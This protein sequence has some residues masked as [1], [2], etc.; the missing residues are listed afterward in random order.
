ML[1]VPDFL[2][3]GMENWGLIIYKESMMLTDESSSSFGEKRLVTTIVCHEIAHQWFG[4]LVTLQWWD[5]LWLNEGFATYMEIVGLNFVNPKWNMDIEFTRS[6]DN[7]MRS[8]DTI[9]SHPI[10]VP[11]AHPGE[12]MKIFDIIS[13]LKCSPCDIVELEFI[14]YQLNQTL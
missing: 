4:N 9:S 12:I 5:D 2:I 1:A 13:Y 7:A 6:V 3:G 11:V 8:D 14:F 10:Y